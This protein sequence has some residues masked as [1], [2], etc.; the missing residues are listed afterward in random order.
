MIERLTKNSLK[1]RIMKKRCYRKHSQ[2]NM[3]EWKGRKA[4]PRRQL[5]PA[6]HGQGGSDDSSTCVMV[7]QSE[8][9]CMSRHILDRKHIETGGQLFGFYTDKGTPVVCYDRP[10]G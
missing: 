10:W 7:Y 6:R 2:R 4:K 1:Y 3:R 8:L 5:A 9:D